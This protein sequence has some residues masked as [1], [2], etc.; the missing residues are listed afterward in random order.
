MMLLQL[1]YRSRS[2][3]RI[4]SSQVSATSKI[5]VFSSTGQAAPWE[6][7]PSRWRRRGAVIYATASATSL[8]YVRNLG[9][10][11]VIDY[12]TKRFED[13]VADVDDVIDLVGG[14]TPNRSWDIVWPGGTIV[15][16]VVPDI[17]DHAP[18]YVIGQF[19]NMGCDGGELARLADDVAARRLA[20]PQL[21]TCAF[22]ALP[23][24]IER[25]KCGRLVGKIVARIASY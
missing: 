20:S 23:D 11:L 1:G 4:N 5:V 15:S 25:I 2:R 13:C 9:A 18:A 21:E 22:D 19:F 6:A 12:R 7:L 14:D 8:D 24:A 3:P 10:A 17:A 16:T